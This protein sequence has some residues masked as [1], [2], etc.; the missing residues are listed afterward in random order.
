MKV[1][2][3]KDIHIA[4]STKLSKKVVFVTKFV[5]DIHVT[6]KGIYFKRTITAI[7]FCVIWQSAG[8]SVSSFSW[9]WWVAL[10]HEF[11]TST[12]TNL[13]KKFQSK[14]EN[15]CIKENTSPKISRTTIIHKN[16]PPQI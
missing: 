3:V 4:Y 10:T 2:I 6:G 1:L 9:Y 13:E 8:K 15:G 5:D 11:T 14:T 16:W 12:N 7:K